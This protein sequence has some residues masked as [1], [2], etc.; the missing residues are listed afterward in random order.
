MGVKKIF[1]LLFF[2]SVNLFSQ[3]IKKDSI[4]YY[5][6]FLDSAIYS[7]DIP[8]SH[9]D[10]Y[11]KVKD[12]NVIVFEKLVKKSLEMKAYRVA[13]IIARN[14]YN[15]TKPKSINEKSKSTRLI[16]EVLVYK[17]EI[18]DS[19]IIGDLYSNIAFQALRSNKM[20]LS[21]ENY[22]FAINYYKNCNT[23]KDSRL[24]LSF[25]YKAKVN[26]FKGN[27]NKA[28]EFYNL[29]IERYT[30]L[31]NIKKILEA[32]SEL[33]I[34]YGQIGLY[35]KSIK[36]FNI[37]INKQNQ[38]DPEGYSLPATYLN[39]GTAYL[40]NNDN[41][42]AIS[43]LNEAV[44]YAKKGN[45]YRTLSESYK[46]LALTYSEIRDKKK[47]LEYLKLCEELIPKMKSYS[48]LDSSR[49]FKAKSSI[50]IS[51]E[52][53]NL[54][55][56]G[57][58]IALS[59]L[60]S[61]TN[62]SNFFESYTLI[63]NLYHGY[64]FK[65][66]SLKAFK[67]LIEVSKIKDSLSNQKK[68]KT[69]LYYQ[70]LYETERKEKEIIQKESAIKELA[71]KNK[72]KEKYLIF[73][74]IGLILFFT[75]IILLRRSIQLKKNKLLQ[76]Q[77]AQNLLNYQEIDRERISK[78]MHDGL[79]YSLMLIKNKV[80]LKKD[81]ETSKLLDNAI[82][83]MRSISR[84]LHPF[85]LEDIGIT[86]TIKNLINE[87]DMNQDEIHIFGDIDIIDHVLPVEKEVNVFRIIQE[88]LTNVVKHSKAVSTKVTIIKKENT[89]TISIKDNGVG[90]DFSKKYSDFKSLGLKTIKERVKMLKG[91]LELNSVKDSGTTFYITIPIL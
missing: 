75:I 85:Q 74:G 71:I 25:L 42:K 64:L 87:L 56:Q 62:S 23:N 41:Q 18:L 44:K 6:K 51:S 77:Y 28:L 90:F 27:L 79:G 22:S 40:K 37:L 70:T 73:G 29:A 46:V 69:L 11:L 55:D 60:N 2:F 68:S 7:K 61:S 49:L 88:C 78:D 19:C 39:L 13:A 58:K 50:F 84:T 83:E 24:G 4:N 80:S 3:E 20:D 48:K 26:Y 34:L 16:N 66:D 65:K 33:A 72:L 63:N 86:T 91:K 12:T 43:I 30:K 31:N 32:R 45:Y 76:E 57:I 14:S 59:Q 89:L 15:Y 8:L 47:S 53:P 82:E 9:L 38:I 1:I 5:L 21:N 67:Y 35:D 10:F 17:D 81:I 54:V 52:D 36:E